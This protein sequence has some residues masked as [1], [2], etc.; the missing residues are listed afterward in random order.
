MGGPEHRWP[1][2]RP[3]LGEIRNWRSGGITIR[4]LTHPGERRLP[5]HR[6]PHVTLCVPVRGHYEER[7]AGRTLH[8]RTGDLVSKP[9]D[10]IHSDRFGAFGCTCLLV[11]VASER[12]ETVGGDFVRGFDEP[13][14]RRSPRFTFLARAV[15]RELGIRDAASW[16]SLEALALELVVVAARAI[17]DGCPREG[18]WLRDVRAL[19]HDR[20]REHLT[21]AEIARA[22]GVSASHLGRCFRTAYGCTVGEYVRELR[23]NWAVDRLRNSTVPIGRIALEA[24][25]YDQSHLGRMV[26]RRLGMTP[27]QVRRQPLS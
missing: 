10:A 8:G 19:L 21:M 13:V 2:V 7:I 26:R 9:P 18:A 11:E 5:P 6:H 23:L 17:S 22:G 4:V 25:F 27:G 1:A 12:L 24:G 14:V 20:F 15:R 3:L 16:L